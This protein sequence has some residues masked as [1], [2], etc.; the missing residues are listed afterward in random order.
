MFPLE[1]PKYIIYAAVKKVNPDSNNVITSSVKEV[2][3]KISKYYNISDSISITSY[4]LDNYNSMKVKDATNDLNSLGINAYV[5]G[6]GDYII[7]Q[8]PKEGASILKGE[9]VYLLTNG[10]NYKMPNMIGWSKSEALSYLKL[11]GITPTFEGIGYVKE[12]S[13]LKNGIITSELVLKLEE[14]YEKE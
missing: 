3:R 11:I 7:N 12:Q 8:Y 2:V 5:L 14:K 1:D 4:N 6:D 9:K 13:I 10:E